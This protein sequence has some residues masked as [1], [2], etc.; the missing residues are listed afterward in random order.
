MSI[1]E[2]R[3]AKGCSSYPRCVEEPVGNE[4][5]ERSYRFLMWAAWLSAISLS[6]CGGSGDP[7]AIPAVPAV[8]TVTYRGKP[9]EKGTIQTMPEKGRPAQGIIK[10]GH[11]ILSTYRDEDGAVP[12]KHQ[13]GVI[14]TEEVKKQGVESEARYVVPERYA[15]PETSEIEVTIP[16][17]GNTKIVIDIPG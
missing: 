14:A 1:P 6:G 10:D 16:P 12:G 15:S 5:C 17:E 11:F 2:G 8:G 13:V 9:V 3:P 4:Q 7:G